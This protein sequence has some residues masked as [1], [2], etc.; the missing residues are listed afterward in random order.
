MYKVI[1]SLCAL[2]LAISAQ[3]QVLKATHH[4]VQYEGRIAKNYDMGE[5]RF[6]W[7]GSY[8]KTKLVGRRLA[9]KLIGQGD[10][11]DVLVNG[12]FYKKIITQFGGVS[13]SVELFSQETEEP[14]VIEVVKRTENYEHFA[15]IKHFDVDGR[16]EGI[17]QQQKHVLYI[18]DSISAGFGSESNKRECTWSEVVNSS[19]ARQA[20]PYMA[21]QVLNTSFTQVSFSGLGLIRNWS[22]NQ[23][24]HDLPYYFDKA[25]AVFDAEVEFQDTYPDLIVVEVGTNDFSTDPQPHEPWQTIAE[26]QQ[27]WVT[28][29]VSFVTTLRSRYP[30]RPIVF[31][32][33]PAYPYDLIISSTEEALK[34]LRKQGQSQLFTKIFSSPL[35][36]C[37]WHPTASEHQTIADDL[38]KFIMQQKLL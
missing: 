20:F 27:A 7:P 28:E 14:V 13:E 1:L 15:T 37:I 10:Q 3:A 34:H 38:A 12:Q 33:R 16:L 8:F 29:M 35:N 25:G 18:G 19:N 21:S 11:F 6:N 5:V 26:V 30:E 36:G 24:Y 17:W 9:V 4:A 32:P 2:G 22:G 23:S 31:M